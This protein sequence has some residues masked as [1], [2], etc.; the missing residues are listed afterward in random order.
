MKA[1]IDREGCI[2]C[3]AC[4]AICPQVFHMA[5]DGLAEAAEQI[6]RADAELAQEAA[7]ACPVEVITIED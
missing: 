4:A 7:Q 6:K 5:E 2:G 3:G 1:C